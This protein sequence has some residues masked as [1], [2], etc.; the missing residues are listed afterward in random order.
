[1]QQEMPG[2]KADIT[3]ENGVFIFRVPEET[4]FQSYYDAVFGAASGCISRI[5]NLE[6][7]L[8]FS[9]KSRNQERDF[10]LLKSL[11]V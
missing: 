9:V 10:R 8:E 4:L 5:R 11:Q 3:L 2:Y 1:M 7:D 6:V